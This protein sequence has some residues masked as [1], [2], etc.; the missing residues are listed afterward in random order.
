MQCGRRYQQ[1]RLRVGPL[2]GY[3]MWQTSPTRSPSHWPAGLLPNSKPNEL[4]E[5]SVVDS[6]SL[7]MS[8]HDDAVRSGSCA[9]HASCCFEGRSLEGG[10]EIRPF[11]TCLLPARSPAC[12]TGTHV[13]QRVI[14]WLK[15]NRVQASAA[16]HIRDLS[17][18][19]AAT[20]TFCL[21]SWSARRLLAEVDISISVFDDG[22]CG[23]QFYL[24]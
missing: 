10:V 16:G 23:K 11:F 14:I 12:L 1:D 2:V 24:S 19:V 7:C 15:K 13:L 21:K 5:V 17:R 20:L 6:P 4:H 22:L 8:Y 18:K 3:T 9:L